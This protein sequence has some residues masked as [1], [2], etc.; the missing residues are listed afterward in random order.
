MVHQQ[1]VNT[2]LHSA[3]EKRVLKNLHSLAVHPLAVE[4]PTQSN[5]Q[6]GREGIEVERVLDSAQRIIQ[7]T[8]WS[9]V[10]ERVRKMSPRSAGI[11][12]HSLLKVLVGSFPI[13]FVT[14]TNH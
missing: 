2:T 14:C 3:K 6:N 13:P 8:H 9:Q 4:A 11:Q 7:P 5:I 1:A 12:R 10:V